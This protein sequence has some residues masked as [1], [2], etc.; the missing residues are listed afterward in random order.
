MLI[1]NSCL[2]DEPIGIGLTWYNVNPA[3][4]PFPS[5]NKKKKKKSGLGL[6]YQCSLPIRRWPSRSWG[7]FGLESDI[8]YLIQHECQT[9]Q[10]K[11]QVRMDVQFWDTPITHKTIDLHCW[12]GRRILTSKPLTGE[13]KPGWEPRKSGLHIFFMTATLW[14]LIYSRMGAPSHRF[15]EGARA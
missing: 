10:L 15:K 3:H 7:P 4:V 8:G 14:K 1:I 9:G 2:P 12:L 6:Y 13:T 11:S 5:L